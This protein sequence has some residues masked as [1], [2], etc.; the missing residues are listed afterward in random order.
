MNVFTND[1]KLFAFVDFSE[2]DA[3]EKVVEK[4]REEPFRLG[5]VTL[6]VQ[7]NRSKNE[8][9]NKARPTPKKE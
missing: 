9:M 8:R 4:A 6:S 2:K 7:I 3:A 5:N 1:V